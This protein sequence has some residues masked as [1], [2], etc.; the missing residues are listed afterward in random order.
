[1]YDRIEIESLASDCHR[2]NHG[3]YRMRY[4]PMTNVLIFNSTVHRIDSERQGMRLRDGRELS[5]KVER[6]VKKKTVRSKS[7]ER[8]THSKKSKH[9]TV[10]RPVDISKRLGKKLCKSDVDDIP[11]GIFSIGNKELTVHDSN[12][13]RSNRV[14]HST[15]SQLPDGNFS[16]IK[17]KV[18]MPSPTS[19]QSSHDGCMLKRKHG[20]S[21]EGGSD[22]DKDEKDN[23]KQKISKETD[24]NLGIALYIV[25][26]TNIINYSIF[27]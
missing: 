13:F 7:K 12:P 20:T 24:N 1:M 19:S 6:S 2:S 14:S 11:N 9:T 17:V 25:F 23:K 16:N 4:I 27:R 18:E 26:V 15:E 22:S 3:E 8:S 5:E 10:K 21:N